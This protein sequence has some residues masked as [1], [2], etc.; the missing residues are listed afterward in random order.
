MQYKNL[1]SIFYSFCLSIF[2]WGT[3]YSVYGVEIFS[4]DATYNTK[5]NIARFSGNIK[6]LFEDATMISDNLDVTF[7]KNNGNKNSQMRIDSASAYGNLKISNS[8]ESATARYG[9]Y[10]GDLQTLTLKD[11]VL[12][13]RGGVEIKAD[14]YKFS[15][16]NESSILNAN[17]NGRV[18]IKI[19]N[20]EGID[21]KR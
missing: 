13:R 16:K 10:N 14:Q 9:F 8:S 17:P 19:E 21:A 3:L 15:L 1:F 7:H 5:S 2:F 20:L 6:V 12:I 11:N 18:K 4:D